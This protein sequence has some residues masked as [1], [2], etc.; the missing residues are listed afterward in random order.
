[1]AAI[2]RII[3]NMSHLV[4]VGKLEGRDHLIV[5][6]VLIT[7]GVHPGSQGPLYYSGDELAKLA[8]VWNTKPVVVY[9][10]EQNGQHV[11]ACS[12]DM[13]N[14]RK[15]GVLL[16]THYADGKLKAEAW[17]EADRLAEVDPRV[18]EA[19]EAGQ[20]MEVS[21]GLYPGQLVEEGGV[22]NGESYV[23]KVADIRPDHLAI[24]PDQV[25]ACS[26]ADG[27]GFLIA[28]RLRRQLGPEAAQ[29]VAHGILANKTGPSNRA[30][31]DAVMGLVRGSH[32]NND[33]ES[34]SKGCYMEDHYPAEKF[35]IFEKSG[36]LYK[37]AYSTTGKQSPP[38]VKLEGMAE[39]VARVVEY[40]TQEGIFVANRKESK[41]SKVELIGAIVANMAAAGTTL[42]A[43]EKT[44]L[45]ALSEQALGK[46]A[47]PVANAFPYKGKGKGKKKMADD[48]EDDEDEP[49]AN[50]RQAAPVA[51]SEAD[52]AAALGVAP[53][54][55]SSALG[56]VVANAQA[57]RASKVAKLVANGWVEAELANIP[58]E[59]LGAI[60]AKLPEPEPVANMLGNYIGLGGQASQVANA[61]TD[62]ALALPSYNF[63]AAS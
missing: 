39:P 18:L 61:A 50:S 49:V 38:Q 48:E 56:V 37:Q 25:G 60:I 22:W 28:N 41:M 31:E 16:N 19:L 36:S 40:R 13:L 42:T 54:V 32:G 52:V 9:H 2:T 27:A 47:G 44:A 20:P 34:F 51:L 3:A 63:G 62:E 55:L 35:V 10:P 57:D 15:V 43:D 4:R 33:P 26:M 59:T 45:E 17:V 29:A 53:G 46:L 23:A 58:T 8:G 24:L 14:A 11:T 7:E 5:P 6:T 12:P 1:M 30:V 21:T